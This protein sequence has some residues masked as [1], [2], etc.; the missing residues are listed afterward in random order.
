MKLPVLSARG[1]IFG[2]AEFLFTE[3]CFLKPDCDVFGT[4]TSHKQLFLK[5]GKRK[6]PTEKINA[7]DYSESN[8]EAM[9]RK[10]KKQIASNVNIILPL[11]D[12]FCPHAH[13]LYLPKTMDKAAGLGRWWSRR[14]MNGFHVFYLFHFPIHVLV[15]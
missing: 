6:L 14:K 15:L 7:L 11:K 3:F 9:E 13:T 5:G 1:N 12:F 8:A 4:K 10:W 2:S